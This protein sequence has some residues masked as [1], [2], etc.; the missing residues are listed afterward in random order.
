MLTPRQNL[1]ECI[2]GGS[3]DRYVNQFEAFF[4]DDSRKPPSGS[5]A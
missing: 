1:M 5:R 4:P 2:R 3:P